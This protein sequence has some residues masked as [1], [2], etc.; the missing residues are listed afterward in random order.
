MKKQN[1]LFIVFSIFTYLFFINISLAQLIDIDPN[2]EKLLENNSEIEVLISLKSN[3][4]SIYSSSVKNPEE[5]EK[6]VKDITEQVDEIQSKVIPFLS[7]D[8]FKLRNKFELSAGFYGNITKKGLDRLKDN[9]HV[10]SITLPEEIHSSGTI[11]E[12]LEEDIGIRESEKQQEIENIII[13]NKNSPKLMKFLL[14]V[15]ILVI[16][17]IIIRR[18]KK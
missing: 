12:I 8:E 14:I 1:F 17:Y 9:P 13:E 3:L 16:L 10:E 4:T 2:I 11:T 6:W 5:R 15:I 18:V 7:E